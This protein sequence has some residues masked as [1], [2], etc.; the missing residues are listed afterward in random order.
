[1]ANRRQKM[2]EGIFATAV[3]DDGTVTIAYPAGTNQAYFTGGN[4]AANGQ[5]VLNDSDV[6]EEGAD[7]F[8]LTYGASNITLTN[9]SGAAWA[10]GTKYRVGLSYG[11]EAYSFGGQKSAAITKLTDN[12][13]G[14]AS[15]TIAAISDAATKNAIASNAAK[16]NRII[17]ALRAAN[18]IVT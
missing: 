7:K 16:I 14:T 2:V 5:L 17:D 11:A 6:L 10:A 1:M 4:A 13:T 3:A 8:S 15:D 12:S 9:L 18:I